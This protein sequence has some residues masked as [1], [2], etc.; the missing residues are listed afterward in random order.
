VI[1]EIGMGAGR[2]AK[3]DSPLPP[4]SGDGAWRAAC[5]RLVIPALE[6]FRP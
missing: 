1:A 4:R 5:D 3:L 2:G 6:A